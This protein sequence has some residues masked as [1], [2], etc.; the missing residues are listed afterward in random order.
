MMDGAE[1]LGAFDLSGSANI[2]IFNNYSE[3]SCN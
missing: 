3:F 1:N 2:S